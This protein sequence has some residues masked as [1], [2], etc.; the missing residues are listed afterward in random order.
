MCALKRRDYLVLLASVTLFGQQD[1]A[2]AILAKVG[3]VY[4][5]LPTSEIKGI[6]LN[7]QHDAWHDSVN[8]TPFILI[9]AQ[10]NKFRSES[11]TKAGTDLQVSDGDKFWNYRAQSNQ[12][13]VG[14]HGTF[15]TY[16]SEY[17]LNLRDPLNNLKEARLIRQEVL[18]T[19]ESK[20]TC[21]VIEAAY[22]TQGSSKVEMGPI[23]IWVDRESRLVWKISVSLVY[24]MLYDGGKSGRIPSTDSIVYSS[25]RTLP[26]VPPDAFVFR[27]PE[28]STEQ[29]FGASD[30]NAQALL[31]RPAPDFKLTNLDGNE[32]HLAGLQGK[33]VLL[34]FW[35]TWCEPCREE[36][37]KLEKLSKKFRDKN[38]TVIGVDVLEDA[39]TV[40]TFVKKNGYTYPILLTSSNDTVIQ[41]YAANAYPSF[42]LIDQSGTVADYKTGSS[43]DN[44]RNLEA[45]FVRVLSPEY[46]PPKAVSPPSAAPISEKNDAAAE[47]PAPITAAD[48]VHRAYESLKTRHQDAAIE[49]ATKA[50]D[51][52][53]GLLAA[54]ECR[55]QALYEAKDYEGAIIEYSGLIEKYPDWAVL[56]NRRG[57][58]YSHSGRFDLAIQD[59]TQ[60]LSLN[61]YSS[62]YLSNRG[63]SYLES[64]DTKRALDDF[65]RAI[66]LSSEYIRAYENR[67]K[68]F[69]RQID[70]KRELADLDVILRIDPKNDWAKRQREML[71]EAP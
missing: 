2:R 35:A 6:R 32:V 47:V 19:G 12:Y 28:G 20:H 52:Q 54:L 43:T 13:M 34:D 26:A 50:L 33:V 48:F 24:D 71:L 38:V 57:L 56:Y 45:A 49:N 29:K 60:A 1:G 11:S 69:G 23:E 8:R 61:H 39:E 9:T 65:N 16:L 36:M 30:K 21:D 63:W 40:R 25:I 15:P 58:A 10:H 22:E 18:E 37:P 41:D 64:G 3:A 46:K 59:Y 44:E 31:G 27:P 55:A 4:R 14:E 42:V 66:E 62:T 67:A 53:P 5:G 7:E 70:P 51:L 17:Q 68:L